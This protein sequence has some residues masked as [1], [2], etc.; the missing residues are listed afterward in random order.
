MQ[1]TPSASRSSSSSSSG[2]PSPARPA[3]NVAPSGSCANAASESVRRSCS[4]ARAHVGSARRAIVAE[5]HELPAARYADALER[6]R[7]LGQRGDE[8]G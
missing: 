1:S 3:V 4:G 8:P 7:D 6:A 2:V 5:Q